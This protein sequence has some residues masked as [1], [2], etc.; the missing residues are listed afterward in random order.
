MFRVLAYPVFCRISRLLVGPSGGPA[1][2]DQVEL[3][4]LRRQLKVLERQL[5]GEVRHRAADRAVLAAL[6]RWLSRA[7][8]RGSPKM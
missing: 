4:V 8:C 6:P 2:D 1:T 3:L 7:K 5:G